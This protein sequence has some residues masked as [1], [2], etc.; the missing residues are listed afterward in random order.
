MEEA[1]IAVDRSVD[2]GEGNCKSG[3]TLGELEEWGLNKE[4]YDT[5]DLKRMLTGRTPNLRVAKNHCGKPCHPKHRCCI[6]LKQEVVAKRYWWCCNGE[7]FR[8]ILRKQKTRTQTTCCRL[9][10]NHYHR[11]FCSW[12]IWG[13]LSMG[14]WSLWGWELDSWRGKL[15]PNQQQG[16]LLWNLPPPY[17][18]DTQTS[19]RHNNIVHIDK[20]E[21]G[22]YD[23]MNMYC[24][25][26]PEKK[27]Q[28][29]KS[30]QAK[31]F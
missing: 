26:F 24:S 20:W 3:F 31:Y 13:P 19:N 2:H 18:P 16:P 4:R 23:V 10:W 11:E 7:S 28:E 6:I 21:V 14:C 27:K 15:K 9:T 25:F 8:E 12:V 17:T 29:N 22:W 5:Q 30:T 1:E